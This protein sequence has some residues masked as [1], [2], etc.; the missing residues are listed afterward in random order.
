MKSTHDNESSPLEHWAL[1]LLLLGVTIALGMILAPFFGTVMWGVIVA[2]LF[3]PVHRRLL[4]R[5]NHRRTAAALVTLLVV[6]VVLVLPCAFVMTALAR[7][8][9]GFY[10]RVHSGQLDLAQ[11]FRGVFDALPSWMGSLLD[12]FGLEDYESLQRRINAAIS[13][14]SQFIAT[15][16]LN[17]GQN[18]FECVACAMR[19]HWRLRTSASSSTSSRPSSARR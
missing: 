11:F 3:A 19:C 14:G 13:E 18:T 4:A 1:P 5:M 10:Q 12:R 6:V 9:A 16:A 15:Q 17:L 2:L 8:A 7:E